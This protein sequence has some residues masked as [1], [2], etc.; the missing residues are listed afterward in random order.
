M[1]TTETDPRDEKLAQL[2][3]RGTGLSQI[4]A[5]LGMELTQLGS[6]LA[7]PRVRKMLQGLNF[8][9][10]M[11]AELVMSQCQLIAAEKSRLLLQELTPGETLRRTC[12]D[13]LTAKVVA[14]PEPP[15]DEPDLYEGLPT[16]EDFERYSREGPPDLSDEP[17][18]PKPLA[19][20][21]RE[22]LTHRSWGTQSLCPSHPQ[23]RS[24]SFPGQY[25]QRAPSTDGSLCDDH[26]RTHHQD[27]RT[28]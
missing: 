16:K 20:G 19:A 1:K 22:G 6:Y 24:P 10:K 5:A 18:W 27:G 25:P 7:E 23:D 3:T 8:A 28:P 17:R 21:A 9:M 14:P 26:A 11:T 12:K 13:V 4:A 15:K 2:M